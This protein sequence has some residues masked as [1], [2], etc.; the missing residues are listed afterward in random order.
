VD[1][2]T[3]ISY[4]C[5][6]QGGLVTFTD[7]NNTVYQYNQINTAGSFTALVIVTT[8]VSLAVENQNTAI[9]YSITNNQFTTSTATYSINLLATYQNASGPYRLMVNGRFMVPRTDPVSDR[10][11]TVRGGSVTRAFLLSNDDQFSADGVTIYTVN[12]ANVVKTVKGTALSGAV[13]NEVLI[14]GS[15]TYN[16]RETDSIAAVAPRG[17]MYDSANSQFT[18][19]YNGV[20]VTYSVGSFVV[21]DNRPVR[22]AF[23]ANVVGSQVTFFDDTS[24]VTF[25]FDKSGNNQI[26]VEFAY[27]NRFFTDVLTGV[28]YYIHDTTKVFQAISYLPETIQ[29]GFVPANGRKYLIHYNNVQVTFPVVSGANVN[30]GVA[31]I[32]ADSF[33]VEVDAVNLEDGQPGA[34]V[35]SIS[36]EI[37]GNLYT[38]T[39]TPVGSNYS[40]CQVVGAGRSPRN[41]ISANTFVL[42]DPSVVYSLLLDASNLPSAITASFA[43]RPSSSFIAV[44]DNIYLISYTSVSTGFLLGQGRS[45]IPISD[46]SFTLSNQFDATR[47][48]FVFANLNIYD[49]A[50]VEGQFTV[51]YSPTF[52][53][54]GTTYT[55]NTSTLVVTDNNKRPFPLITNPAMFSINGSNYVIDTNQTPHTIV[56][57]SVR[58]PIST[59]V[60]VDQGRIIP[61]STFVLNG[62]NYKYTEDDLHN[63][64]IITSINTYAINQPAM[65]FRLDSSLLLTIS[66]SPPATGNFVGS[67]TPVG[68]VSAGPLV[69]NV[70]PGSAQSGSADLFIYKGILYTLIKSG[71]V[72]VAVQKAYSVYAAQ[73][74]GGQQQLAVFNLGG[75][76]YLLTSGSRAGDVI[77]AGTD[78]GNMWAA[79]ATS[80]PESQFGQV[81]GFGPQPTPVVKAAKTGQ[82]QFQTTDATGDTTV[83]DIIYT[84]GSNKN[85]IRVDVPT[86]LPSF[87]QSWAFGY[88]LPSF[89]LRFETGGYDAYA[90]SVDGRAEPSESFSMAYRTPLVCNDGLIDELISAVGDFTVEFWHSEP[91]ALPIL[92]HPFTYSASNKSPLVYH[93]DIGFQYV[94]LDLSTTGFEQ[95]NVYVQVNDVV[96]IT[97][98]APPLL[99]SRWRHLALTY[100]QP[101]AITCQGAGFEV[102]DGSNYNFNRDFSIGM[103]FMVTD[104]MTKQGLLYKGAATK[105]MS[106][107]VSFSY[108][109]TVESNIVKFY[110][111]TGG[112]QP[113]V[114]S[115]PTIL[116]NQLYEVF[117]SKQTVIPTGSPEDPYSVP[118]DSATFNAGTSGAAVTTSGSGTVTISNVTMVNPAGITSFVDKATKQSGTKAF[119][120]VIA[121]RTV[122]FDGSFGRWTP[123]P[124]TASPFTVT[125]DSGLLVN[126]TGSGHL[127]IGSAFDSNGT[128]WPLG[129]RKT[130]GTIRQAFLFSTA[131]SYK[132]IKTA[133]G[134][135]PISQTSIEDL[136]RAGILGH[137]AAQYDASGVVNNALDKDAFATS[138]NPE[139]AFLAPLTGH[140]NEG[141]SLSLNGH[142]MPLKLIEHDSITAMMPSYSPG[143]SL[144]TFNAGIYRL[145]EISIWRMCRQPSQ[146][147]TD[148]FG[149]LVPGN[150][151]LLALYLKGSVDVASLN[152]KSD[153]GSSSALLP[154]NPWID[155]IDVTNQI[156]PMVLTFSNVSISLGGCPTIGR[157]GPLVTPNPTAPT[158]T[159]IQLNSCVGKGIHRHSDPC[160]CCLNMSHSGTLLPKVGIWNIAA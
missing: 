138:T 71:G 21:V 116:P 97:A 141:I 27:S 113:A 14:S 90:T 28:T 130:P 140:E 52:L 81:Y 100:A 127:V 135:S 48:R 72:Y 22:G 150:E 60:T 144:L 26:T 56:G 123:D 128:E 143:N 54:G 111:M 85:V 151:P 64:L 73:P 89:P 62:L 76:T 20:N 53:L 107:D 25:T 55:L 120:A 105:A 9:V 102:K 33:S 57:N 65:T 83:Y 160:Y 68:V 119:Q 92:Y 154:L 11:Y 125:D 93:V 118:I 112:S 49:A 157:C 61:N 91:T 108:M 158:R 80:P 63:L 146:I 46:S 44:N 96:M 75:T 155:H 117:V 67:I 6:N 132:G 103:T 137:W 18:V 5:T 156:K 37:N 3:K 51:Y 35:N 114:F 88:P 43:V 70:Y 4:T 126:D 19:S 34:L 147:L 104:T 139:A 121:V 29:Y 41:F 42:T 124:I 66:T 115:G 82:F 47:A 129:G 16:L 87:V 145:T 152:T 15:L 74:A 8:A 31:T 133:A 38:I 36:F 153:S 159:R 142:V 122:N 10:I 106:P 32:G 79:T 134:Y 39:G 99:S 69:L 45:S 17:L 23:D 86:L 94:P 149:R 7:S 13:P 110:L 101:Y 131:Q 84:S 109:L 2:V 95:H 50:S 59:D 77:P 30:A 24:S 78:P 40:T 136:I 58:S 12:A 148:M 98:T 1:P